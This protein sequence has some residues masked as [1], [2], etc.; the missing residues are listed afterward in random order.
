MGA[1]VVVTNKGTSLV[2]VAGLLLL[3]CSSQNSPQGPP[4]GS[5]GSAGS[6]AGSPVDGYPSCNTNCGL[7]T[8]PLV[9]QSAP[10]D[11]TFEVGQIPPDPNNVRV[12][13]TMNAAAVTVPQDDLNGWVYEPGMLSITLEGSFCERVRDGTLTDLLMLFG[14]PLCPIP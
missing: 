12:R 13:A 3:A 14:C 1:L 4:G 11:C 10:N 8:H 5:G 6:D 7:T 9:R 2:G